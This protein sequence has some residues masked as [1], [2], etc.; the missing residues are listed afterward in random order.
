M[1]GSQFFFIR[2]AKLERFVIDNRQGYDIGHSGGAN[3]N[4]RV[5]WSVRA[6]LER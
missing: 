4:F 3:F 6:P 1:Y 2:S 5:E